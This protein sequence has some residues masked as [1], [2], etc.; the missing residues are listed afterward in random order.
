MTTITAN[1]EGARLM[2]SGVQT[3]MADNGTEQEWLAASG[4]DY[5][6]KS[7]PVAYQTGRGLM[8]DDT[9]LVHYRSD[10]GATVGVTSARY[11]PMQPKHIIQTFQRLVDYPL[12]AAGECNGIIW[13]KARAPHDICIG[14]DRIAQELMLS[15]KNDGT[16]AIAL[17][18][19][20]NRTS[21]TN[22]L[23][24]LISGPNGKPLYYVRHTSFYDLDEAHRLLSLTAEQQEAV[25]AELDNWAST[26]RTQRQVVNFYAEVFAKRDDNGNITN[27]STL[28]RV[29]NKVMDSYF[30]APG[31]SLK[32]AKGTSWGML[33]GLTHYIDH[34][35]PTRND[36]RYASA[37]FGE[38]ARLKQRGLELLRDG[39]TQVVVT[40]VDVTDKSFDDLLA[41]PHH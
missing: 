16:A 3:T 22:Q 4:L 18:Y 37:N 19:N 41:L 20:A 40:E 12:V 32:S 1:V 31:Q 10:N 11:K 5:T 2:E 30:D 38:G 25:I 23:A 17:R 9:K 26:G 7:T 24:N 34:Q 36:G 27:E 29:V 35:R 21:C 14:D 39:T 15:T 28:E 33:N 8:V 13:A 6:V